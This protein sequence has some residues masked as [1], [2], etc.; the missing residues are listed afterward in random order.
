MDIRNLEG[1][2]RI[3]R[4]R[5]DGLLGRCHHDEPDSALHRYSRVIGARAPLSGNAVSQD[6]G[7]LKL[8]GPNLH[9]PTIR[10]RLKSPFIPESINRG[11]RSADTAT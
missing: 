6:S 1:F 11:F 4:Y 2:Y 7:L 8:T 3:R 9:A 10:F 5:F